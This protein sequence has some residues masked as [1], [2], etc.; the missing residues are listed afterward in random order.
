[1]HSA[2]AGR[3]D[4]GHQPVTG[5]RG[6]CDSRRCWFCGS[7]CAPPPAPTR[8]ER[9]GLRVRPERRRDVVLELLPGSALRRRERRLL[10]LVLGRAPAGV[11]M[12]R[13]LSR[14]ARVAPLSEPC[15]RPLRPPQ[16]HSARDDCH[17]RPLRGGER[18]LEGDDLRWRRS[19]RRVLRDG[20]R[21]SL[22]VADPEPR[23]ARLVQRGVVPHRRLAAGRR[24]SLR[25]AGRSDRDGLD[26]DSADPG[27][28]RRGRPRHRLPADGELQHPLQQRADG[29]RIRASN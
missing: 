28:N 8:I 6:R 10:L 2:H 18:P 27:D 1:M 9:A 14:S 19:Q 11:G 26:R 20:D 7:V 24:L 12:E 13:A 4:A 25:K 15:R 17:C 16:G 3:P 22:D 5:G 23:R 29:S 21:L